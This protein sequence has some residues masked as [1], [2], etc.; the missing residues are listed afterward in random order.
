MTEDYIEVMDEEKEEADVDLSR[1]PIEKLK[2][3]DLEN[4]TVAEETRSG[5]N[6]IRTCL[7]CGR[8]FKGN[9]AAIRVHLIP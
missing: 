4:S 5:A 9:P 3:S 2:G 6:K 1:R 8:S 7:F